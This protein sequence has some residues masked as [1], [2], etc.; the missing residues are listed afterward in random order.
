MD[1]NNTN[2]IIEPQ[3]EK[4]G[5]LKKIVSNSVVLFT[6]ELFKIAV[7][8]FVIVAPIRYF[9]FQPFIVNGESMMPNFKSGDYLIVDEISYR[10]SE[11]QRGD[12]VV[13]NTDFIPSYSG[14]RFIKRVIGLP[15]ETINI[16][17]G[18][19]DIVKDGK[20]TVLSEKYLPA[21]LETYPEVK[22]TLKSDEY[23]VL[24]DNRIKSYDSRFWGVV[25]K[26]YII[27]KA[28]LR[29]FPVAALSQI[30]H[31]AY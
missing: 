10:F 9:L 12:V 28:F 19:V 17:N 25:Q 20:T 22:T 27:G 1:E 31:P 23:F 8:A 7:I 30:A 13:F 3:L 15:G 16:T 4:Q 5:F 26:K 2:K 6:W 11:P 21:N 14:Q 29:I 18:Q 24:G